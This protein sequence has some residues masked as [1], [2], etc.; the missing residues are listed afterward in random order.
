[1]LPLWTKDK[2]L[3]RRLVEQECH[4]CPLNITSPD[5]PNLS[6][7]FM[8]GYLLW[9]TAASRVRELSKATGIGIVWATVG[10]DRAS[11]WTPSTVSFYL[12]WLT[13]AIMSLAVP[14]WFVIRRAWRPKDAIAG[15]VLIALHRVKMEEILAR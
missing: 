12:L 6:F 4:A 14:M 2:F 13:P 10:L 7:I 5:E 3:R 11:D 8:P 1:V 9:G 15:E